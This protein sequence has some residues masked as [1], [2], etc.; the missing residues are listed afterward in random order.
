[1]IDLFIKILL[2]VILACMAIFTATFTVWVLVAAWRDGKKG[3]KHED[4]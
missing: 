1:M 2:I 3:D 4:H